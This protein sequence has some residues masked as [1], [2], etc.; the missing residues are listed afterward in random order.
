MKRLL[1]ILLVGSFLPLKAQIR[2]FSIDLSVN[3]PVIAD[4]SKKPNVYGTTPT[5]GY[6][7]VTNPWTIHEQYEEK[8]GL[9]LTTTFQAFTFK[10]FF[11]ET[12]LGLQRYRYTRSTYVE[13][14]SSGLNPGTLQYPIVDG[15]PYGSIIGSWFQRDPDGN[16]IVNP[17]GQLSLLP[18]PSENVG[19]TTTLYLQLPVTVGKFF[20]KNKLLVNVGLTA[21]IL[22]LSTEVKSSY[23]MENN[24]LVYNEYKDKR[25]EGFSS[26]ML[27]GLFQTSY[28]ITKN[29][30]IDLT[31]QRSF[32]SIYSDSEIGKSYYNILSFGG[33]YHFF[34]SKQ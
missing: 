18:Q 7:S 15:Q 2:N 21:D 17:G 19:K 20:L 23:S 22:M 34:K 31:Y 28:F 12:G 27:S 30:G 16:I 33:S 14:Q 6:Y 26:V 24:Q 32:T 8:P 5:T 3:R 29:I 9:S 10:N 11:I 13:A 4:I 1:L 25:V